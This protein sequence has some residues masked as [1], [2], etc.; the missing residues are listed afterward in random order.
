MKRAML[1]V[2]SPRGQ[3]STSLSIG[4]YLLKQL[5][6]LGYT[7]K[8]RF[9]G[10]LKS[11]DKTLLSEICNSDTILLASPLYGDAIP[12]PVTFALETIASHRRTIRNPKPQWFTCI[13]N[14]GFPEHH[15]NE[16]AV[17]ICR[18]FSESA[19]FKWAG[20]LMLGAGEVIGGKPIETLGFMIRNVRKSLELASRDLAEKREISREAFRLMEKPMMPSWLYCLIGNIRFKRNARQNGVY[21]RFYGRPYD[22]V[23]V[24]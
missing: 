22:N 14:C 2:G 8:T 12:Y 6:I 15:H 18:K 10:R 19:G 3:A 17:A 23:V 24:E 21:G 9:I 16:I 20:G 4:T 11:M 1:L 5:E 13:F 7:S